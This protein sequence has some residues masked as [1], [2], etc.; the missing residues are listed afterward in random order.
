MSH[1]C[2]QIHAFS[3]CMCLC[4]IDVPISLGKVY[5]KKIS[6][7]SKTKN[8]VEKTRPICPSFNILATSLHWHLLTSPIPV[9]PLLCLRFSIYSACLILELEISSKHK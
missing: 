8:I 2:L 9:I 6:T 7:I 3:L 4:V 5:A 1:A